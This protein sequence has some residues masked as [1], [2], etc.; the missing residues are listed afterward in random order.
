MRFIRCARYREEQ[1]LYAFQYC[2]NIYYR[3]FRDIPVG[4]ELLVWYDDKYH[5]YMGLPTGLHDMAIIDPTGESRDLIL[6]PIID[7]S[8]ETRHPTRTV[9]D[10]STNEP[11]AHSRPRA[12]HQEKVIYKEVENS[13]AN[14]ICNCVCYKRANRFSPS[15]SLLLFNICCLFNSSCFG[16][17]SLLQKSC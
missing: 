13:F 9:I 16:I 5:Q 11:V 17:L 2:G 3:A 12:K 4:R 6:R 14:C 10:A 15:T 7:S 8:A 1:N